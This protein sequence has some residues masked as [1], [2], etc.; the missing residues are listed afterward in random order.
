[1]CLMW[2]IKKTNKLGDISWYVSLIQE[3]IEKRQMFGV[4]G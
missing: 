1:M 2:N 3:E 4:L